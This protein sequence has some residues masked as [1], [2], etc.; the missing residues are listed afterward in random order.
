MEFTHFIRQVLDEAQD[1]SLTHLG[2]VKGETK[3]DKNQVLTEA[4][5]AVGKHIIERIKTEFPDH[6]IIDEEAGVIDNKSEYTWV[7]DPI[8]GTS[9][10][11][12][13]TA[14]WGIYM[15]LLKNYK[16]IAGGTALPAF[17]EIY[18]AEKGQGVTCSGVAIR[19]SEE[20]ELL[21]VL[22]AYGIDGDHEHPENTKKELQT[23]ADI[24]VQVRN[25]RNSGSAYDHMQVARGRYGASLNRVSKIWDNVAQQVIMTEAGCKYTDFHGNE[26]DYSKGLI[27]PEANYTL[28]SAPPHLHAELQ[29]IIKGSLSS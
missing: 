13:G 12:A 24:A 20:P 17:G 14:L 2:N 25:L 5:I 9:N 11:A 1:I 19:A 28:C 21:N 29:S 23:V 6:N 7:I 22:V 4:D 18:V 3:D 27:D 10:F 8:D 26:M 15:G 16:P